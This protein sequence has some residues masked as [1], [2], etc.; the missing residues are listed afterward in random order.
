MPRFAPAPWPTVFCALRGAV[1]GVVV[2]GIFALSLAYAERVIAEEAERLTSDR[3]GVEILGATILLGFEIAVPAS[4]VA[5]FV[6]AW[7]LRLRRPWLVA[8]LGLLFSCVLTWAVASMYENPMPDWGSA[9]VLALAFAGA[10]IVPPNGGWARRDASAT[11]PS[12][13]Q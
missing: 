9:T 10:A 12:R 3:N 13:R 5:G 2:W 7:I 8:P 4:L 6:L 1:V 11:G